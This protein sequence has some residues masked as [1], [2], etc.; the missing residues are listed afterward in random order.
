MEYGFDSLVHHTVTLLF[1]LLQT[2]FVPEEADFGSR[3]EMGHMSELQDKKLC[4][5]NQEHQFTSDVHK[6][7]SMQRFISKKHLQSHCE[8]QALACD[9]CKKIFKCPSA[10]KL[11]VCSYRREKQFKCDV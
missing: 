10:L 1:F 5:H 3:Q 9:V 8:E 7:S 6:K 11:H 2:I 4:I